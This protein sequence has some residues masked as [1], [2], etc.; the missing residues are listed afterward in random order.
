[1]FI[2]KPFIQKKL[3]ENGFGGSFMQSKEYAYR[4]TYGRLSICDGPWAHFMKLSPPPH[5]HQK[6][7]FQKGEAKK[8]LMTFINNCNQFSEYFDML[9]ETTGCMISSFCC[10][11]NEILLFWECYAA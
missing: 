4:N 10:S 5:P 11:V 3:R 2:R 8:K 9:S 7:N 6:K 1:V